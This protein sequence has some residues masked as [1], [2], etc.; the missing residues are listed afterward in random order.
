MSSSG[1]SPVKQA[2]V[3]LEQMRARV[4]ELERSRSEP[5][6]IVGM[7]CRV[8][9]AADTERFWELLKEGRD[10]IGEVP[11]SRWDAA[12]F[13][14]EDP[15]KPGTITTRRGGFLDCIDEFEPE[16][17]GISPREA[18]AIDPQ[19]RLLLEVAWEALENAGQ[20]AARLAESTTGVFIGITGDEFAQLFH[21]AA[22]VRLFDMYFASGVARSVAAGRISYALG[23]HGPSLAIDTACSSSLVAVHS[24]CLHLRAGECRAAL[25]GGVNIILSPEITMAFSR[26]RMMAADGRCKTFDAAADGF[27]RAEGCGVVVLK[28]LSDAQADG[29]NILAVIRGAAVN[30]DGRSSGLTVPNGS[31]Q[32]AVMR[33]ALANARV[34]PSQIDYV[35]A[36]G[37]GTSLGDPIEAHAL[38]AVL[39]AGRDASHPLVVGSV[40]TNVGHLEAAAGVTGL[41]KVVLA[42]QHE[43]IPPHLHFQTMNPH[44][45]WKGLPVEIPVKGKDWKAGSRPRLAG[46]SSFGFSGTNAHLIVEQ[47]P[48]PQERQAAAPERG[49]HI[50]ALSALTESAL[51]TLAERYAAHL[52]HSDAA[53]GDLCYTA[54]AGR[55]HFAERA[56]YLAASREELRTKLIEGTALRGRARGR[57]GLRIAFLFSGQGAQY[58]GMGRELYETEPVFRNALERCATALEG[59]LSP[60]LLDVLYGDANDRLDDTRYT[61][62]ALFA[63]EYALAELWRSWG[64]EPSVVLGH[65][66]GEYAAACVAGLCSLEDAI[67]LVA[68]RGRLMGDLPKGE[69]AMAAILAPEDKVLAAV[70]AAGGGVSAA[71]FNGPENVVISGRVA[72]V[73]RIAAGFAAEGV[74]VERLCVSHAFHSL[75]MEPIE[76]EFARRAAQVE[77]RTPRVALISSVTGR[78]AKAVELGD[79][80][81]WRRQ[82]R[83]PVRF[84]EAIET[85]AGQ[86]CDGFVEIGPGSTLLGMGKNCAGGQERLWTPSIRRAKRDQQQMAESVAALYA[87]G[88]EIDWDS[89]EAGR[90]HR[91]L[92]LPTYPFERQ[93]YW[94]EGLAAGRRTTPS[95]GLWAGRSPAPLGSHPLLGHQVD[96]AGDADITVWQSEISLESHPWIG[97][98]RVHELAIVPMTA[99]L[100]MMSA[101]VG[102]ALS[103]V[104]IREPL[105]VPEEQPV[106]VQVVVKQHAAEV[107]SRDGEDWKLH[108]SGRRASVEPPPAA[109]DVAAL[110]SLFSGRMD[111]AAFYEDLAARGHGFGPSFCLV[112][113]VFTRDGEALAEVDAAPQAGSGYQIHPAVLDACLQTIAGA[114]EAHSRDSYLPVGAGYFEVTAAP[115][116]E[117]LWAHATVEQ[118]REVLTAVIEVLD[119]NGRMVACI[120]DLELRRMTADAIARFGA[121]AA[122]GV[123]FA[124]AWEP[125]AA[126]IDP[127]AIA[128]VVRGETGAAIEQHGMAAYPAF[129]EQVDRECAQA[130]VNALDA[131]GA[132][133]SPGVRLGSA[134]LARRCGVLE[135]HAMLFD[136]LLEIL[137]EDGWL[138]QDEGV[139]ECIRPLE[140]RATNWPSLEARF[141][142]FA[143]ETGI[144]ARCAEGLSGVLRGSA[145]ELQL[146]FPGGSTASAERLYSESPGA[147]AFNQLLGGAIA[148]AIP[149]TGKLKILEAGAGTGGTST[150]VL[151]LLPADRTGYVFSD[152]SPLFT[153]RAQQR[154]AAFPFV[155]Y[156]TLDLERDPLAQGFEADA[157]DVVI[158]ANVVHA[159]ADL[160]ATLD[161]LRRVLKPGGLLVLLEVIRKERWIDISFGMTEGWWRFTDRELRPSYAL[162]PPDRWKD[163]L[164]RCGFTGAEAIEAGPDSLNAILLAKKSA[165]E[166]H[167]SGDWLVAGRSGLLPQIAGALERGGAHCSVAGND[168]RQAVELKTWSGVV[169]VAPPENERA[170]CE[171]VLEIVHALG[172]A[173][174][175]LLL[176]TSGAQPAGPARAVDPAQAVLWGLG[177]TIA[178]ECPALQVSCIDLD[179]AE[180][181]SCGDAVAR[182]ASAADGE[183]EVAYRAGVRYV[184]RLRP[185]LLEE[186]AGRVRL[187]VDQRG[188][189]DNLRI[190]PAERRTPG[191]GQVEI[192]VAVA[193]MGFRDVLNVLG[194]YP[195]DPGPLGAECAGRIAAVG[196]DVTEFAPGDEV[197][198]IAPGAHDGYVVAEA[199]LVAR[200]PAELPIED[201]MTLPVPYSTAM[202]ALEHVGHIRAGERVLIHSGAGGVGLAAIHVARR[203]GAEVFA[204]AG[205]EEKC[206]LL[207]SLGV[208]HVMSSRSTDFAAEIEQAT[209]GRGVDVVLNSLA[210]ET[211]AASFACLARGGR[212][213]EIGK[214]GIWSPEQVAALGK[215]IAYSVID[216]SQELRGNAGLIGALLQRIVTD[217]AAGRL[218]PLPRTVFEF[219]DAAAAYRYMA[220]A[221]HTGRIL[222]RQHAALAIR[223]DRTYL[224]SGGLSGVGLLTAGYLVDHGARHLALVGRRAPSEQAAGRIAEFQRQGVQVKVAAADV[225]ERSQMNRLFAD[226]GRSMP[227]L[228][229]VVHS[230][231]TLDDAVL[232]DQSWDRFETVFRSKVQGTWNLHELTA[233]APLDFFLLYSSIASVLGAPGQANHAAASAFEDAV[234]WARRN[235]GLPATSINWGAWKGAGSADRVEY[236]RR[237]ERIG[238]FA[239]DPER[240]LDFLDRV[241]RANPVQVGVAQ[242]DWKRYADGHLV[243]KSLEPM[244]ESAAS[245]KAGKPADKAA[246]DAKTPALL[247]ELAAAPEASRVRILNNHVHLLATRILGLP[248]ERTIDGRKPLHEL[249]LDSLMAVEFR[250]GLSTAIGRPLPVTLLFSYPTIDDLTAFLAEDLTSVAS[251]PAKQPANGSASLLDA[252]EELSDEEVDR[253]LAEKMGDRV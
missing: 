170:A 222:L 5:I 195:G 165:A 28:R 44:I 67:G 137:A 81:Y 24:A 151:P 87:R 138:R 37:T 30:Q 190:E 128:D 217:A 101:A 68:M 46:V 241:L 123:F 200:R 242:M 19:Q 144:A 105:V 83:E 52:A 56:V 237:R 247:E 31:A 150:F 59:E 117:R 152:V 126:A 250:N 180:S 186:R 176:V 69:G 225:G 89:Y 198:A 163:L 26:A 188:E 162:L 148:A 39:G 82:V 118:G 203:M 13:Y 109:V 78:A 160:G 169:F 20:S 16:F 158:A 32:E 172:D 107:Y 49:V 196:K 192:E 4:E 179:P 234:A 154:F 86:G 249:G 92:P 17:F 40:K 93:R 74:R 146:L 212:F 130:I 91:R 10:A 114:V 166:P 181:A 159:T 161:H 58:A 23:L 218:Q 12:A 96:V 205:T 207:R 47:A 231:G 253:L 8:P 42:L 173:A 62:P 103:E 127:A 251:A 235:N 149:A 216:W 48:P 245:G 65:S 141:P 157:Y 125:A 3:A 213:L 164:E 113:E 102:G 55:S 246:A 238:L 27:V 6:A 204:T 106:E 97:D 232:G 45:D 184:N 134:E 70:A 177:R 119:G 54:T 210:G 1:L 236:E 221:R 61:Q 36:H 224:I 18:R 21:K 60:G 9:G 233:G 88:A 189:I 108:A 175:R 111:S 171:P 77:F 187:S 80:D 208:S 124:P 153:A 252:V 143:I 33:Q 99:Y 219:S 228:G 243:P 100:E 155:S 15:D 66:I 57:G 2:L 214:N 72:E 121:S 116:A 76:Q 129:R 230:A 178:A 25:A 147:R 43:H 201:A 112:R 95:G 174:T 248:H 215:D 156:A 63:I 145:D 202:Y 73:E 34:E 183:S 191:R 133:W 206:E 85:L 79:G 41:I 110:R 35:E 94:L 244:V 142:A 227:P 136:R 120:R 104:V 90:G 64:V 209:G 98:H 140:K 7:A 182:E 22:D 185:V 51:S 226:I 14:D 132:Q 115:A 239:F 84:R 167:L 168:L 223:A 194:M 50:L 131:L 11:K 122:G 75:L 53:L 139:W 38:A 29:D 229:G 199:A 220:Q 71:A 135:R 240:G 193:G 211:I 197:I